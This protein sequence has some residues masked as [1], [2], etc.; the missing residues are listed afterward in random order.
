[1]IL[2]IRTTSVIQRLKQIIGKER[3]MLCGDVCDQN[4]INE[5]F[6]TFDISGVIHFAAYKAVGESV[7]NPLKYYSNNISGLNSILTVI[8][9]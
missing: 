2:G 6:Q 5:V 4:K 7:E 8:K 1:M 9:K 3:S